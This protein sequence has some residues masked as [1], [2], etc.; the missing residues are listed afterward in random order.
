MKERKRTIL[1]TIFT[2]VLLISLALTDRSGAFAQEN[3][4]NNEN[5]QFGLGNLQTTQIQP[6]IRNLT[7]LTKRILSNTNYQPTPG[8]EYL[9]MV[10]MENLQTYLL[11]LQENYDLDVPYIGTINTKNKSFLQ[12]RNFII[13]KI[14]SS[15]PTEYVSFILKSPAQFDIFIYGGVKVP[16]II[17][18]NPLTRVWDAIALA[19]GFK[20]GG[21]LRHV[22]LERGNKKYT[23]DLTKFI[24]DADL[25]ANPLLRPGDKIYVPPAQIVVEISGKVMYPGKYELLPGESLYDLINYAGGLLPDANRDRIKVAQFNGENMIRV[26][27]VSYKDSK[28]I[29]PKNGYRITVNSTL[30]NIGM[31]TVEGALYGKPLNGAKPIKIPT[32]KILL[33]IPYTKGL[34]LLRVLKQL[35]GPTPFAEADKSFIISGIDG[36]KHPVNVRKLWEG[37]NPKDDIKLSPGDYIVIPMKTLEVY[38]SGEVNTPGAIPYQTGYTVADYIAAA[39]GINTDKGDKNGIYFID[40][41][42]HRTRTNL[43]ADVKPGSVIY[44]DKNL[45][46]KTQDN[47]NNI[48]VVTSFVTSLI[49]FTTLILNF[50]NTM[51]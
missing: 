13:N 32:N 38:V 18:V 14:K 9:L 49:N 10:K 51:K 45:W 5:S 43:L 26:S 4:E 22:I 33:N 48:V 8:D 44:V 37:K 19:K 17:T 21:S 50:I 46:T 30:Q 20:P 42:G 34:T 3:Q 16:G 11:I 24:I 12:L 2:F 39:G 28:N 41:S 25:K 27:F 23:L 7:Q 40:K 35:G 6:S 36:Q 29:F 15:I 31:V 47:F 1:T